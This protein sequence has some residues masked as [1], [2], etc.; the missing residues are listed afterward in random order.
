MSDDFRNHTLQLWTSNSFRRFGFRDGG[1]A[2]EPIKQND[3]HPDLL[4]PGGPDG[5]VVRRFLATWNACRGIPLELL[6]T[7]PTAAAAGLA[8]V[9]RATA[10]RDALIAT[11]RDIEK[12]ALAIGAELSP[13]IGAGPAPNEFRAIAAM[14]AAALAGKQ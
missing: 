8:T 9:Q 2:C 7:F 13:G 6:E 11:L 14:C 5:P 10:E 3:G 1:L 12:R 4:F